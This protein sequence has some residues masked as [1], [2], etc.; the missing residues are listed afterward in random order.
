MITE[1]I[2]SSFGKIG[3]R[4]Q[5]SVGTVPAI[6]SSSE[7]TDR[8]GYE[9]FL[10]HVWES[11][12]TAAKILFFVVVTP[13]MLTS[14]GKERFGLFALANFFVALM[15]VLDLGLRALTR[16]ALSN[17]SITQEAK[18]LRYAGNIAAFALASASV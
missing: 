10:N 4:R 5:S 15:V 17:N 11:L 8:H 18:V 14:W 9:L 3:K 1:A 13:L 16:V 12:N 6:C 2:F 7:M